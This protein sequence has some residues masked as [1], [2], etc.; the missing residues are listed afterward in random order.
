MRAEAYLSVVPQKSPD[1]AQETG[2]ASPS[3]PIVD[4]PVSDIASPS[5]AV[6]PST[7]TQGAEMQGRSANRS[8]A[9]QRELGAL[10]KKERKRYF[11]F[12][13]YFIPN[14]SIPLARPGGYYSS[15]QRLASQ[16]RDLQGG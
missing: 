7:L 4:P 2:R 12:C 13:P 14:G 11:S 15:F 8:A 10:A 9:V 16:A 5:R 1:V 3:V 6:S